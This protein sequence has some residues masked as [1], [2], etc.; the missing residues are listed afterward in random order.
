MMTE[1]HCLLRYKSFS[2]SSDNIGDIT[3]K[4]EAQIAVI[5][6]LGMFVGIRISR[7]TNLSKVK[8]VTVFLLLSAIDLLCVYQEIRRYHDLFMDSSNTEC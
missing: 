4:G 5:D 7:S 3:A 8:I 2:Q 6:L 1:L